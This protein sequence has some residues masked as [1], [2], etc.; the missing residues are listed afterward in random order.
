MRQQKQSEKN[1]GIQGIQAYQREDLA[2]KANLG[3]TAT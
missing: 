3:C 1:K 2:L